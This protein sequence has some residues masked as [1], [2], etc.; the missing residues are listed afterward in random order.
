MGY[1]IMVPQQHAVEG[2]GGGDQLLSVLR[3]D[4]ALDELVDRRIL[5]ADE[6]ARAR[7]VSGFRTPELALLI[8]WRQRFGPSALGKIVIP[9]PQA[10]LVLR[11]IDVSHRDRHAQPLQRR[12]IKQ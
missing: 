10:V 12:L 11:L 6:V 8:A 1:H 3:E 4:N 7:V 9:F 5:D 2:P